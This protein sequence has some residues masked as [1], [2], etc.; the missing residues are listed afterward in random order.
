MKILRALIKLF[1]FSS[2]LM[3]I[4][5]GSIAVYMNLYG[6]SHLKKALSEL[7]GA[8][9][10]FR[11]V[12]LDLNKLAASF[13]GLTIANQIGFEKNILNADTLMVS[14]NKEKLEKERK[15][16][17]D[18]IYIKGAKLYIIRNSAGIF[19]ISVPNMD[20]AM[21]GE[22]LFGSGN[23]AY[24]AETG[25]NNPFYDLLKNL[26]H[27]RVEDSSILFEDSFKMA[28]PYKMWCDK[29][30]A[31]VISNEAG[32]GH[33]ATTVV[34][35][36]VLPQSRGGNGWLGMKAS[37]AVY[38]DGT[39]ME[40]TAET[41]NIELPI[42]MPYFE[43]NTPFYFRSGRFRSK[44]NFRLRGGNIDSL[45]TLYISNMNLRINPHD[46]SAQFLNVSINRLEP[47]LLYGDDNVFDFVI[48]GNISEP[49]FGVGPKV[50]LAIEMATMGEL[51][52]AIQQIR[53]MQ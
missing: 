50:K 8:E 17:F 43:R 53:K 20:T 29:L 4:I 48:T 14:L 32:S 5:I 16:V 37:M 46:P 12:A 18:S 2:L 44:T 19:N 23:L 33:L 41:G 30:S 24:A 52:K 28:K 47:Y 45:T 26:R 10:E 22:S 11:S 15:L 6:S 7:S 13:R 42:F 39:N 1:V 35:S 51:A 9:V 25:S 40:M 27:I 38:P 34:M 36:L 49:Q 3:A 21:L 31:E